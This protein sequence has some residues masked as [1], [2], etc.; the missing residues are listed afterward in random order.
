MS[1]L[2]LFN[3]NRTQPFIITLFMAIM[4]FKR[5]C[6]LMRKRLQVMKKR[7]HSHQLSLFRRQLKKSNNDVVE[8]ARGRDVI[9][10][11]FIQNQINAERNPQPKVHPSNE[12]KP[13]RKISMQKKVRRYLD[14]YAV[15]VR[16]GKGAPATV[17]R[18]QKSLVIHDAPRSHHHHGGGKHGML[19]R[20]SM[21]IMS[22]IKSGAD[23]KASNERP[24]TAPAGHAQPQNQ[25]QQHQ[26]PQDQPAEEEGAGGADDE[27]GYE[28]GTHIY[29]G[30]TIALQVL[31][32]VVLF[33]FVSVIL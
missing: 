25:H 27:L 12:P 20:K 31:L 2:N 13:V 10:P 29:F 28:P 17:D 19:H 24:N 21:M 4:A 5:V 14:D 32:I 30:A 6:K 1:S 3:P 15:K 8:A 18:L 11:T 9:E 26:N 7:T 33:A 22:A 23:P 16:L